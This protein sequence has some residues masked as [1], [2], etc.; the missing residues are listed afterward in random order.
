MPLDDEA[1]LR[2]PPAQV[3][4]PVLETQQESPDDFDFTIPSPQASPSF[5]R[6]HRGPRSQ[7][8]MS[9]I[10][11][12]DVQP[13]GSVARQ[14]FPNAIPSATAQ[15]SKAKAAEDIPAASTDE[16]REVTPLPVI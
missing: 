14:V 16:E 5:R 2:T 7:A 9:S 13:T 4:T 3:T 10:P 6:L 11:E 12:E 15:E 8:S 1:I